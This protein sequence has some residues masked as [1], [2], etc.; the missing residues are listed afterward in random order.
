MGVAEPSVSCGQLLKSHFCGSLLS[1]RYPI[2]SHAP[3]HSPPPPGSGAWD[4]EI[5]CNFLSLALWPPLQPKAQR[6]KQ[7][8]APSSL[9]NPHA[10]WAASTSVPLLTLF[11]GLERPRFSP[12]SILPDP[13]L[14]APPSRLAQVPTRHWPLLRPLLSLQDQVL[15]LCGDQHLHTDTRLGD[16]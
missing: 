9:P 2:P 6:W 12:L 10:H 14:V 4:L 1:H 8:S 3:D 5:H 7:P 13:G 16:G 11:P 15:S